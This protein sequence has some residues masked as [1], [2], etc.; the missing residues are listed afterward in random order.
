MLVIAHVIAIACY[1]A[2]AVLAA[3]PF[4]RPI[5]APVRGVIALL[6]AGVA[7]HLVALLAYT[8]Q[9]GQ[10][11]LTGL[12]PALSTA[13]FLVAVTLVSVEAL[14]REVSLTLV[15]APLAAVVTAGALASPFSPGPSAASGGGLW[16]HLHIALSLLG[17][18]AFATAAASGAMYLLERRELKSR[19]FGAIFRFFPP[20]DTLDRV[21]HLAIVCGWI[22]I[23]LGTALAVGY[24]LVYRDADQLKV[25]WGVTAWLAITALTVGRVVA[26]WQAARAAIWSS[27][28]FVAVV[29]LYVAFRAVGPRTG[30]FL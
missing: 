3:A 17:F 14:A 30:E 16:L 18:A 26:G 11:P 20:L 8:W 15:T 24:S 13:A 6:S 29:T 19:R 10:P 1:I 2:A 28:F 5:A 9:F 12:G 21:N 22:S 25:I 4:A 23:T 7:V 27:A